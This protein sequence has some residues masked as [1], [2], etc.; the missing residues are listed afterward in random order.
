MVYKKDGTFRDLYRGVGTNRDALSSL[1]VSS[2]EYF[3]RDELERYFLNLFPVR[4][5]CSILPTFSLQK[6]GELIF[7][8]Q[9]YPKIND[10]VMNF[11][12]NSK[13]PDD[14]GNYGL[15]IWTYFRKAQTIANLHGGAGLVLFIDDGNMMNFEQPVQP[16]NI[17]FLKGMRL[18]DRWDLYPDIENHEGELE[19]EYYILNGGRNSKKSLRIHKS[20]V[21]AF[22]GPLVSDY[23]SYLSDGW[24][25]D[26]LVRSIIEA[27]KAYV[28][29][30]NLA[31]HSLQSFEVLNLKIDSFYDK[32]AADNQAMGMNGS[33]ESSLRDRS[34]ALLSGL[35]NYNLLVTDQG[36]EDL[37]YIQR[38][39][40]GVS[41]ILE[42]LEEYLAA[43]VGIPKFLLFQRYGSKMGQLGEHEQRS[44]GQI[45]NSVQQECFQEPM[46]L[47]LYYI[48]K[49]K[50]GPTNGEVPEGWKWK[51]NSVREPTE[52]ELAEVREID[53]R[54]FTNHLRAGVLY[55]N[56]IRQSVYGGA[57]YSREINIDV[58]YEQPETPEKP[59]NNAMPN[60][61]LQG[62]ITVSNE[63]STSGGGTPLINFSP[64]I[65]Y[66]DS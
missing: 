9:K 58:Q 12:K 43:A 11:L 2:V 21:L 65:E 49:S 3:D 54:T 61:P 55:P 53:S 36:R 25:G 66:K 17:K 59:Q 41:D 39:F 33:Y 46:E 24:K 42:S 57:E 16:E 31:G 40:S 19:P 28:S 35:S 30:H 7:S 38:Q 37:D 15:G 14:N 50:Y 20:R 23:V 1:Q 18:F 64:L 10:A 4:R 13:I 45:I 63:S 32:L 51:W 22:H 34:E 5:A 47:I 62:V 6:G 44:F 8:G 48:F 60:N 56:E 52:R 29:A 27:S 26:T